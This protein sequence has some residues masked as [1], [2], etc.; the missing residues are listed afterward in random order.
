MAGIRRQHREISFLPA[1]L[2]I[3]LSLGLVLP[4]LHGSG[5]GDSGEATSLPI[6]LP[7]SILGTTLTDI[8]GSKVQPLHCAGDQ[9][10]VVLIFT[11]VDC[12][13]ANAFAP[14]IGRIAEDYGKKGIRLTLGHA[15][16]SLDPKEA[17][18]H[19]S[20]YALDSHA[21]IVIDREH[22]LVNAAGATVTPEAVVITREGSIVYR[23][24][25]NDLYAGFGDKRAAPSEHDLRNALDAVIQGQPVRVA[26]TPCIGCIIEPL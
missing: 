21:S 6:D 23:G 12:P 5:A 7:R 11:S 14:E 8:S 24:R 20:D 3:L 4:G 1:F 15:D 10:A 25:I 18:A 26:S 17:T 9:P 13:I 22:L 2:G 19:A 16:P